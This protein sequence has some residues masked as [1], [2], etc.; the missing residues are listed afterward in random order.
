MECGWCD[1]YFYDRWDINEH[2]REGCIKEVEN[3]LVGKRYGYEYY[4]HLYEDEEKR[5]EQ[6]SKEN[7]RL[8]ERN[9]FLESKGVKEEMLKDEIKR[10]QEENKYI[11]QQLDNYLIKK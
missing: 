8:E 3:E 11:K 9:I 6:L 7:K 5:N 1:K 10:L 2:Q 4:K